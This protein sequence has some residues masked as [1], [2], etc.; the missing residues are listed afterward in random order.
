MNDLGH[1]IDIIRSAN[2]MAAAA[3]NFMNAGFMRKGVPHAYAM[4]S[5]KFIETITRRYSISKRLP[6]LPRNSKQVEHFARVHKMTSYQWRLLMQRY[7]ELKPWMDQVE[8]KLKCTR[9]ITK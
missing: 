6:H 7:P 8:G 1:A 5:K 4:S 9:R 2:D 3:I